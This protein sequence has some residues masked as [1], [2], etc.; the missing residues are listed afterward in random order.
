MNIF[1]DTCPSDCPITRPMAKRA[2][3]GNGTAFCVRGFSLA[4]SLLA[5]EIPLSTLIQN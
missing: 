5:A 2:S 1:S 4:A 3:N